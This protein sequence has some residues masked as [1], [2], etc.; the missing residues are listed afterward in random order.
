MSDLPG[1]LW[2]L[3]CGCLGRSELC[4]VRLVSSRA[5]PEATRHLFQNISLDTKETSLSRFIALV[6]RSGHRSRICDHVKRV[7]F[8]ISIPPLISLFDA[9]NHYSDRADQRI[10]ER[11]VDTLQPCLTGHRL[12]CKH[13]LETF[14]KLPNLNAVAIGATPST[15]FA[16]RRQSCSY[17]VDRSFLQICR[18]AL[19]SKTKLESFGIYTAAT[20]LIYN[21]IFERPRRRRDPDSHQVR[22]WR[23]YG[24]SWNRLATEVSQDLSFL[25][26]L[27]HFNLDI[28]FCALRAVS[29][30][31]LN[32]NHSRSWLKDALSAMAPN[33][34]RLSLQFRFSD[35]SRLDSS[36]LCFTHR[37]V[38]PSSGQL[39]EYCWEVCMP[40]TR[41][42]KLRTLHL[43][44]VLLSTGVTLASFLERHRN[45]LES[46]RLA[47]W[48]CLPRLPCPV[49]LSHMTPQAAPELLKLVTFTSCGAEARIDDESGKSLVVRCQ[50]QQQLYTKG[51][52]CE[53]NA[54]RLQQLYSAGL[55]REH[56]VLAIM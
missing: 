35:G 52:F 54:E 48:T 49:Q 8:D 27:K 9:S 11:S 36:H 18:L 31:I 12:N 42:L 2:A 40:D 29:P 39:P 21:T 10:R 15:T 1:E 14:R 30:G 23:Q 17:I 50:R 6:E 28:D 45:T 3:I 25:A 7:N 51:M 4:S 43:K 47:P 24:G 37:P 34:E 5:C 46:I 56:V 38:V 13:L 55:R 26:N 33:I 22:Y 20:G 53:V 41:F 44:N 32:Q 19:R 16:G